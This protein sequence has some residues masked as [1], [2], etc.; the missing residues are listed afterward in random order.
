MNQKNN[1]NRYAGLKDEELAERILSL[2][3]AVDSIVAHRP[4]SYGERMAIELEEY[5]I[6]TAPARGPGPKMYEAMSRLRGALDS[7]PG[8]VMYLGPTSL[9]MPYTS[10]V[11]NEPTATKQ[12]ITDYIDKF[13]GCEPRKPNPEAI[14]GCV[15][16]TTSTITAFRAW[17]VGGNRLQPM[18]RNDPK[19]W[20]P[21]SPAIG[22]CAHGGPTATCSCGL[23]AFKDPALVAA[24][25]IPNYHNVVIG[26]VE[27]WGRYVEHER[28]WRA[29]YGYPKEL[30]VTRPE[31]ERIAFDY[32]CLV[33][34]PENEAAGIARDPRNVVFSHSDKPTSLGWEITAQCMDCGAFAYACF[35]QK[36]MEEEPQVIHGIQE[37]LL[38]SI[39]HKVR[40]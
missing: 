29:Q 30:W 21:G 31:H 38:F 16:D 37:K 33:R 13:K 19:A 18:A 22:V 15:P 4:L 35:N 40:G 39:E 32:G 7:S 8:Q 17:K 28:G 9:S 34:V 24:E 11:V 14:P 36:E 10:W 6:C 20:I 2:K 25:Y 23:H 26:V 5:D 1:P 12:S 27:L 3:A